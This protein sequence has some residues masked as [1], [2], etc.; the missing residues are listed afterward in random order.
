MY[1]LNKNKYYYSEAFA[2]KVVDKI[3]AGDTM[4]AMVASILR[5]NKDNDLALFLG[6]LAG[7]QSVETIGNSQ[8]LN[9]I[10]LLKTI[11]YLFK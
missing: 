6:S 3:G 5:I 7:A 2:S 4:M 8:P 10:K 9:K 1:N 11:E